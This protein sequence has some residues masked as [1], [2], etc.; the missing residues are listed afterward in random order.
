[1]SKN[2]T[3][4][5]ENASRTGNLRPRRFAPRP[6]ESINQ[7]F[8]AFDV[9]VIGP[10]VEKRREDSTCVFDTKLKQSTTR[11]Q[12][13]NPPDWRSVF[14]NIP[15]LIEDPKYHMLAWRYPKRRRTWNLGLRAA[16]QE[17]KSLVSCHLLGVETWQEKNTVD[18]SDILQTSWGW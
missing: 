4:I 16:H 6:L 12:V 11:I 5:C 2:H 1:M 10:W 17:L 18:S 14:P 13:F 9:Q 7:G 3:K 15:T 8:D